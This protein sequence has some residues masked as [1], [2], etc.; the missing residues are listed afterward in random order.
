MKDLACTW[1]AVGRL[2]NLPIA[3]TCRRRNTAPLE[4]VPFASP[5]RTLGR[6][7]S[8]WAA[9]TYFTAVEGWI[10]MRRMR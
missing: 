3:E 4:Y 8:G 7:L 6:A 9:F 5:H 10:P 2:P 1:S